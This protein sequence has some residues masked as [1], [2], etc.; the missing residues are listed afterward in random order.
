MRPRFDWAVAVALATVLS[1]AATANAQESQYSVRQVQQALVDDGYELG[2]VDGFWGRRS[3]NALR[4]FQKAR[5]LAQTGILDDA[6]ISVLFPPPKVTRT[7]LPSIGTELPA[8]VS[9][10]RTELQA[11]TAPA[12]MKDAEAPENPGDAKQTPIFQPSVD[13]GSGKSDRVTPEPDEFDGLASSTWRLIYTALLGIAAALFFLRKSRKRL[14]GDE[15]QSHSGARNIEPDL[16]FDSVGG[17][18]GH[19]NFVPNDPIVSAH[20]ATDRPMIGRKPALPPAAVTSPAEHD[21]AIQGFVRR[22]GT[23]SPPKAAENHPDGQSTVPA[24]ADG[25]SVETT[26]GIR[27]TLASHNAKVA[28]F[29]RRRGAIIPD[30]AAEAEAPRFDWL[31]APQ[32]QASRSSSSCWLPSDVLTTV[33]VTTVP[34]GLIYVGSRLPKRGRPLEPENCLINPKL[35]IASQGDPLGQTMGYWPS[36]SNISPAA[37]KSYLDWLAG[38]RSDPTTYIGYVFL[39]FYGLERRLMLE[40]NADDAAKVVAEVRRLLQVYGG[41][42]SFKR[43]AG[44]LLSAY[45]LKAARLPETLYLEVE[46]NSY[47]IPVMLKAALGMRVRSREAIEPDLLFAYVIADPETRV[48][49]PARRAQTMLRELFANEVEKRYPDGVRISAAH[50]RKLTI[51]YRACSGS[52]DLEIHPFGGDL[53]DIT[54]LSEPITTARRIFDECTDRLDDYSRM[55]GRSEGLKPTLAAVAK[56][57][58]G[59]R[60]RNAEQLAD[61]PLCKLEELADNGTPISIQDL[62]ELTGVGSDKLATRAKQKEFSGM[63]AAFGYGHTADPSFSFRTAKLDELSIVFRLESEAAADPEPGE[64][65]RPLQLSIMLGTVIAFADGHLHPLERRKLRDRIE[66]ALGLSIDE[67]VRLETELKICELDASRVADW[68]KRIGD[69]PEARREDLADELVAVAA[70]DG[71]LHAREVS[72]LEKLFRHMGL[73]E[74]SLYSRLHG[75]LAPQNIPA[76]AG[77]ELPLIISAGSQPAGTPI[78][79]AP[80]KASVTHIDTSRLELIRRETQTTASVLADIF[81]EEEEQPTEPLPMVE[82][83]DTPDEGARFDGLERRYGWLLSELLG[84]ATW[85]PGDFERLVRSVDLMPGAAKQTLNDWSLDSFDELV[86]EGDDPIAVNS[87]LFPEVASLPP[88]LAVS[89]EGISA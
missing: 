81:A 58:V 21:A 17:G 67:R 68:T 70:A 73:D 19:N 31:P 24:K 11:E 39:Y 44:E 27:E 5:D 3:I 53:P 60:V 64:H 62:A 80:P 83:I 37:R 8:P 28:E 55:L 1:I 61:H 10:V 75:S 42:G 6:T 88:S 85:T 71:I 66:G 54:N 69:V 38:S 72:Q 41:N 12:G 78:P 74:T 43:Y 22:R 13:G 65:Y 79:P 59:L 57:P 77:D 18:G 82:E 36:Y 14:A 86:L 52:F 7:P 87:D 23:I 50:T 51:N 30:T 25:E 76:D 56:L 26:N 63:L 33:G 35:A 46:E 49:T 89:I 84:Q 20:V 16:D 9:K 34:G 2:A 48:R 15:A 47:E 40:E 32:L 29:I 45:E 4:A